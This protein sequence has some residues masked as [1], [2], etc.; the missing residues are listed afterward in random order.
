MFMSDEFVIS[1]GP[2]GRRKNDGVVGLS[3]RHWLDVRR[4]TVKP[5]SEPSL[6]MRDRELL[7]ESEVC[8]A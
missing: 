4:C 1:A 5:D 2:P 3:V 7:F 8:K 6:E